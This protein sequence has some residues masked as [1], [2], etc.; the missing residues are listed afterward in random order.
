[1][2]NRS[3]NVNWKEVCLSANTCVWFCFLAQMIEAFQ[4]CNFKKDGW[5][6]NDLW[7]T[8]YTRTRW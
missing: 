7:F 8:R 5:F 6:V 1:M 3:F 2:V 4:L